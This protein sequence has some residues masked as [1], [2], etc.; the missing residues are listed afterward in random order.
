MDL[1][2]F[3]ADLHLHSPYSG[4]VSKNMLLPVLAEQAKLKGLQV[5]ATGDILCKEWFAH[6]EKNLEKKNGCFA[7]EEFN[8]NFILSTEINDVHNVHHL[9][10][11]EDFEKVQELREKLLKFGKLDGK[12]FGRPTIK[13]NGEELAEK[14][15][16]CNGLIGAAHAF[17][18]YFSIY[19]HYNSL[20]ECYGKNFEK[21]KFI[22][23]GLSADSALADLIEGNHSM[24]F[25]T[26]SDAHSPWPVRL[27]REFVRIKMEKGNFSELKKALAREGKRGI[28][29]NAGLDPREG[30]Y[31]CTA[32]NSCFTKYSLEDAV[33]LKWKCLKCNGAIKKGV[34]DRILELANFSEEIHPKFRP[35]YLHIIPLA[36]IIKI[37]LNIKNENSKEVQCTWKDF[38][39]TFKTEI[40]VL[41]DE[42]IVNLTEANARVAEKIEAFRNSWVLYKA[43][44]GGNYGTPII[45][46]SLQEME[47]EKIEL[48]NELDCASGFKGQKTLGDF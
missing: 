27:G 5:L 17:T 40:N 33:K 9:V 21:V 22:E 16:E 29:L 35:N 3:N 25:L 6:A 30:K 18:P 12:G 48:K 36:E 39:E 15:F 23:L 38:V 31:H 37:A 46:A 8:V 24:E 45:C 4:G 2:E 47:R 32:C 26:A 14:V 42:P 19:S 44:G 1:K 34:H 20:K 13:L 28:V 7:I 10:F 41:I 11:L 43:G